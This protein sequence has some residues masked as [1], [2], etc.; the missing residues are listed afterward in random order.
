MQWGQLNFLPEQGFKVSE[1]CSMMGV[2]KTEGTLE[3]RM[4][5]FGTSVSCKKVMPI[6]TRPT[7]WLC[8]TVYILHIVLYRT[9]V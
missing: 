4:R 1:V 2:R 9:A 8:N 3:R 6:L 7:Q 5:S